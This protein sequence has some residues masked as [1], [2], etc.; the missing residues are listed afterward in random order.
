MAFDKESIDLVTP[1]P[2][3][4]EVIKTKITFKKGIIA[5]ILILGLI[6]AIGILIGYGLGQYSAASYYSE[7][8]ADQAKKCI[9]L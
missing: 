6:L 7:L 1:L 9:I 4:E 2:T 5:G 8:L 3:G